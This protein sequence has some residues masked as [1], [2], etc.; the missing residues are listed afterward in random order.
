MADTPNPK[1]IE[2]PD[3]QG[4]MIDNPDFDPEK[5]EDG[6]PI[7]KKEDKDDLAP[8]KDNLNKAY[9]ARDDALE[10]VKKLKKEKRDAELEK[11]KTEG[12][13]N[14]HYEGRLKDK[15]DEIS[16]LKQEIV[17][18]RR[19]NT[20]QQ[21]LSTV[22]FRNERA[23]KTAQRD[24][25][26]ELVENEKGE[27]VHKSG[28]SIAD[29]IKSFVEDEDNAFLF[30]AKENKGTQTPQ[31]KGQKQV[32]TGTKKLRDRTVAEVLKLAAEG[33]L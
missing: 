33:K 18:L 9:K 7:E 14:E 6:T 22:T 13:T 2:D 10:E 17:K 20:V 8:I 11:L 28:K 25:I 3:N 19:D 21:S 30:P 15:D 32:D 27:W 4:Q 31:N 26:S 29:Y 23:A 16:E 1:Q 12:K 24:V 5:N